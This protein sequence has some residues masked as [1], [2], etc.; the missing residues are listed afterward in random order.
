MKSQNTIVISIRNSKAVAKAQAEGNLV[1]IGRAMRYSFDA[2]VRT[3]SKWAN[4]FNIGPTCTREESLVLYADYLMGRQD[5]L[6]AIPELR[7]K[8]LACWCKPEFACHGDILAKWA[9][10]GIPKNE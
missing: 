9:N 2:F 1:Y 10:E 3:G 6:D 5:L 4:P 8:V 7:G